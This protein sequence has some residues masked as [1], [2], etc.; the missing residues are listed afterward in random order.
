MYAQKALQTWHNNQAVFA[1]SQS[2]GALQ[3]RGKSREYL[4]LL[5]FS[6][7]RFFVFNCPLCRNELFGFSFSTV[8]FVEMNCS[9][10]RVQLFTLSFFTFKIDAFIFS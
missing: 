7:D 4:V 5:S 8:H 10:Y 9:V 3:Y 2:I 1:H 6:S